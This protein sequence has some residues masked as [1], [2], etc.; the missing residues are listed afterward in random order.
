MIPGFA[1]RRPV[2]R[3]SGS[4][5]SESRDGFGSRPSVVEPTPLKRQ[6]LR[7]GLLWAVLVPLLGSTS[8][9][10]QRHPAAEQ[11]A[12]TAAVLEY[13]T[14]VTEKAILAAPD[15]NWGR[16]KELGIWR[17]RGSSTIS[18]FLPDQLHEHLTFFFRTYGVTA[19]QQFHLFWDG[20]NLAG[21]RQGKEL[22]LDL[23]PRFLGPGKHFLEIKRVVLGEPI[24]NTFQ[25]IGFSMGGTETPL[26][27]EDLDRLRY[28]VDFL[29][30]GVTGMDRQSYGGVLFEGNGSLETSV[31]LPSSGFLD[32][33]LENFSNQEARFEIKRGESTEAV[34]VEKMASQPFRLPLPG[35][36]Q[37]LE[38]RVDGDGDGLYL[39]GEP[40]AEL[41]RQTQETPI[42]LITLDTTRRDALSP[43]NG[44][45]KVTPHIQKLASR[46]T[47]YDNAF[48]VSPWTLPS[49]ASIMTGL[50]PSKHGAGVRS[51]FLR[52]EVPTLARS[53]R[54][55]GYLTAGF[56]GGRL[57]SHT[58]GVGQG[59][60]RYLDPETFETTGDQMTDE[61][62]EVVEKHRGKNL[63]VFANYF[64]PHALYKAPEEFQQRLDLQ[65]HRE[66]L[67]EHRLWQFFDQGSADA[68]RQ[69]ID[70]GT[71]APSREILAYLEA[72]YLS[73]VAFMDAQLGR[74]FDRLRQLD[75][76][77]RSLIILVSDHGELRGEYGGLFS[78]AGRLD[79]E[80]TEIPLIIKWPHQ[81][82]GQ[83]VESLV[84]QV[85]LFASILTA[86]GI[87][88]PAHDGQL[89]AAAVEEERKAR[90]IFLEEH[91][92]RVHPLP[93]RLKIAPHVYGVQRL[94]RRQ[95]VWK[96]GGHCYRQENGAWRE[97]TCQT[98]P[99]EAL[100][101]VEQT[102]GRPATVVDA[103]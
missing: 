92:S 5:S 35:G 99:E 75:L 85:D 103:G 74:L 81:R 70:G 2:S 97:E 82:K 95:I 53:L 67:K 61:V 49:H 73:E 1:L 100:S 87:D 9:A 48:S 55:R 44:R 88:A 65:R 91:E 22:S 40:T 18:V 63:F 32:M 11:Q 60:S 84:S 80:L 72:A 25:D 69:I 21:F 102:L 27:V 42:F 54:T 13:G 31:D 57:C 26:L 50:Y 23:P 14:M 90:L 10:C 7:R 38:L 41:D 29:N 79:P 16:H 51:Q 30:V 47:V 36:T 28:L 86:V 59:F 98:S 19:E 24:Q 89:L 64:D 101:R 58:F 52:E 94:R 83:R 20:E 43:Y 76:F 68:W 3:P 77:D 8:T 96:S 45:T 78:H 37:N 62:L 71:P 12:V 4:E 33:V 6:A 15:R 34:T 46:A 56:A 66:A 93:R 39:W 17:F